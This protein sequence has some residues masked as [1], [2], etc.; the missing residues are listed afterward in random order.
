M[1]VKAG[2][3]TEARRETK[4]VLYCRASLV[5]PQEETGSAEAW[6]VTPTKGTPGCTR[7]PHSPTPL[8][9][10]RVLPPVT[11][12][13]KDAASPCRHLPC[14]AVGSSAQSAR[15]PSIMLEGA[16]G[17]STAVPGQSF[18]QTQGTVGLLILQPP[19]PPP[20]LFPVSVGETAA[21]GERMGVGKS[22]ERQGGAENQA[23]IFL[24]S[25]TSSTL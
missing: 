1:G 17:A 24:C 14:T 6:K 22:R 13:W 19:T 12:G 7:H 15:I 9:T 3:E 2:A 8:I 21:V 4:H 23:P 18:L 20:S 11:G 25:A 10:L 16:A 5:K